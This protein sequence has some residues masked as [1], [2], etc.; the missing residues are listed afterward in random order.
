M[1][2]PLAKRWDPQHQVSCGKTCAPTAEAVALPSGTVQNPQDRCCHRVDLSCTCSREH[3]FNLYFD[4]VT[5]EVRRININA[6]FTHLYTAE[7][8][9]QTITL[10]DATF[11]KFAPR[12]VQQIFPVVW[13]LDYSSWMRM[14]RDTG[15]WLNAENGANYD[16]IC[17]GWSS[18]ISY[19]VFELYLVQYFSLNVGRKW[20]TAS[21]GSATI[22]Y[23]IP[24]SPR[25]KYSGLPYIC[26]PVHMRKKSHGQ[27]PSECH[28]NV[29]S[30]PFI[31]FLEPPLSWSFPCSRYISPL[32]HMKDCLYSKLMQRNLNVLERT[33]A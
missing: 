21:A 15:R 31:F 26:G 1:C 33:L 2:I 20:G 10:T 8:N 19:K 32:Y 28:P 29:A 9:S 17:D 16:T 7:P 5:Y 30:A 6:T 24:I 13:N 22:G 12:T 23:L 18:C 25:N 4:L 14:E 11:D 3:L 27:L